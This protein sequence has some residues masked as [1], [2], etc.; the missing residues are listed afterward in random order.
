M[1]ELGFPAALTDRFKPVRLLGR[2]GFGSVWLAQQ[3]A[4]E[5]PVAIKMLNADLVDTEEQV[6]RFQDEARLTANLRHPGVVTLLDHGLTGGTPWMAFEYVEGQSLR[7]WV[8]RGPAPWREVLEVGRQVAHALEEARRSGVIHR[9]IKPD[10]ILQAGPRSFKIADFGIAK[11]A[12]NNTKTA[13][14]MVLGTPAYLSPQ[15]VKGH[16]PAHQSDLYALGVTLYELLSARTPFV[17]DN[18]ILMLERHMTAPVPRLRDL[19]PDLPE[20][21]ERLI[22]RLLAKEREGRYE[23]AQE[24]AQRIGE[25]LDGGPASAE[26]PAGLRSGRVGRP[27]PDGSGGVTRPLAR[28]SLPRFASMKLMTPTAMKLAR[29]A[30]GPAG[31]LLAIGACALGLVALAWRGSP[32]A[33]PS[34]SVSVTAIATPARPPDLREARAIARSAV[35]IYEDATALEL[36]QPAD[37]DILIDLDSRRSKLN[38]Q[39]LE[40]LVRS[41]RDLVQRLRTY[42]GP[43]CDELNL[44]HTA[45][46]PLMHVAQTVLRKLLIHAAAL[47]ARQAPNSD[48]TVAFKSL[49]REL[50]GLEASDRASRRALRAELAPLLE[51]YI[52]GEVTAQCFPPEVVE[53]R[54]RAL[55]MLEP[56]L[57]VVDPREQPLLL[58]R[59]ALLELRIVDDLSAVQGTLLAIDRPRAVAAAVASG[60]LL[61]KLADLAPRV[62]E[63]F[64]AHPETPLRREIVVRLFSACANLIRIAPSA[65][66]PDARAGLRAMERM[67]VLGW[68]EWSA[69]HPL[70]GSIDFAISI[71]EHKPGLDLGGPEWPTLRAALERFRSPAERA[72]SHR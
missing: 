10:N 66:H 44:V 26:P 8:E 64:A 24:L 57:A 45:S 16:M 19:V 5:R 20:P 31:V 46:E 30:R 56:L 17:D 55:A 12:G 65:S 42:E 4:L 58:S 11:W 18:P 70:D 60:K 35:A 29:A 25:L 15:Q 59:V 7:A 50:E 39:E 9:D 47:R 21:V 6:S 48:L 51:L 14:G 1:T 63:A 69:R 28:P 72:A 36:R 53:A 34:P 37:T 2:G 41:F 52:K 32:A 33:R 68:P 61:R 3:T 13:A 54:E 71:L 43:E 62:A 40:R 23:T 49:L 67:A 27:A 38:G 22:H